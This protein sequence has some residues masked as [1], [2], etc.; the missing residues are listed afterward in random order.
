MY[1]QR[2]TSGLLITGCGQKDKFFNAKFETVLDPS[3]TKIN[4]VPQK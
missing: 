2:N 3:I 1:W 4:I